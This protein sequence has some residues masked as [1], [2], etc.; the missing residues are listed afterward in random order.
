LDKNTAV[1]T[2]GEVDSGISLILEPIKSGCEISYPSRDR[3]LYPAGVPLSQ[4]GCKSAPSEL[5]GDLSLRLRPGDKRDPRSNQALLS[6]G[7][8]IECDLREVEHP[9]GRFLREDGTRYDIC[10]MELTSDP[11]L[12]PPAVSRANFV[13]DR[14]DTQAGVIRLGNVRQSSFRLCL[15][16]PGEAFGTSTAASKSLI[17]LAE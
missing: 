5:A 8:A 12:R 1:Y 15:I 13:G 4:N 16:S 2:I 11:T 14:A 3:L 10:V 9:E 17:T 7:V 6:T